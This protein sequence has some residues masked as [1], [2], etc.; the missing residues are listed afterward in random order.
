MKQIRPDLWETEVER[1]LPGLTTHAY[2]LIREDGNVLF[3]NT[4]LK[5]EIDRIAELGGVAYHYL[6]HRDELGDSVNTIAERFGAKLGGHPAERAEFA[7]IREPDLLFERRGMYPGAV[8][9]IPTPGHSPGSTCFV[10]VS[11]GGERLLFTGDTLYRGAEGLWKPGFIPGFS[12]PEDIP[13]LARS[14][15]SL[16][17]LRPDLVVGSAFGGS[18]GFEELSPG[19]WPG[20]V[21]RALEALNALKV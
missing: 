5:P 19:E 21:D 10:A 20:R 7:R 3:Y 16:R 9:A 13:T 8:E 1:P 2:L 14:I 17:E 11:R 12:R 18:M 15:E 4:S 6:S